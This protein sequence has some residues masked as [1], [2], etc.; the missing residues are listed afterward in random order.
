[1]D[2]TQKRL[3]QIELLGGLGAGIL[4]AGVA[5]VLVRW[6]Q[7]YALPILMVGIVSHGW[8]MLAKNRLER[9]ADIARPIWTVA[10]EW[11]CWLMIAALII[12]VTVLSMR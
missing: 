4:G 12:Y 10:A 11:V 2:T 6:L 3:K 9:Q 1:M 5:L 7:P 8:A